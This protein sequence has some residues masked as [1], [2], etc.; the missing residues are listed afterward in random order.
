MLDQRMRAAGLCRCE[1][2]RTSLCCGAQAARLSM[3]WKYAATLAL[4]SR[5]M[6]DFLPDNTED[7]AFSATSTSAAAICWQRLIG[8][9]VATRCFRCVS[10]AIEWVLPFP[11]GLAPASTRSITGL[12]RY[13]RLPVMLLAS[14][15]IKKFTSLFGLAAQTRQRTALRP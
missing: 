13:A 6:I 8:V 10:F 2:S 1:R 11:H 15:Q 4:K 3:C 12:V 7:A 5:K 9:V 14:R